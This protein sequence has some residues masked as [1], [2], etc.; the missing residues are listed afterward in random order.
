M[1]IA[2]AGYDGTV[3]QEDWA[4]MAQFTGVDTAVAG[5]GELAVT[6]VEGVRLVDVAPGTAW[7]WGVIDWLTDT[8]TV[9]LTANGTG[10][11]RWDAIVLRRDWT[12]GTSSLAAVEGT[13]V[14]AVPTLT[15]TPGVQADQVLALVAVPPGASSLV[16]AVVR[17]RTQY[18]VQMTTGVYPPHNPS[19]GQQWVDYFSRAVYRFNGLLWEDMSATPIGTVVM[20]AGQ[21][22]PTGWHLCDGSLHGSAALQDVIG[23]TRTPDLR[24]RFPVAAGPGYS[25]GSVGGAAQVALTA[26]QMPVHTHAVQVREGTTD[27]GDGTWVD[28]ASDGSTTQRS[29]GTTTAA[30]GGQ[31]HENRPPYYALNFIIRKG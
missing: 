8:N 29:V 13:S 12:T 25:P 22:A 7:G 17:R 24:G 4:L 1:A 19:I 9:Q 18:P 11:T 23:S 6:G 16:G 21:T 26:A 30:G 3:T 10:S 2:S 27:A 14:E 15:V 20:F 28:T 5:S 31:A